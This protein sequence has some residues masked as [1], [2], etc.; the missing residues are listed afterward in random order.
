VKTRKAGVAGDF[1]KIKRQV[2]TEVN[3]LA[4]AVEPFQNLGC[5]KS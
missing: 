3:K 2:V 4:G 1:F 5:G